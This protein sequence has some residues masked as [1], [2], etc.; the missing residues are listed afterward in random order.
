MKSHQCRR[1]FGSALL[2]RLAAVVI[3]VITAVVAIT[4]LEITPALAHGEKAQMPFLRMRSIQ[5]FDIAWSK[6]DVKVGETVEMT[7]KFHVSQYW[8][9]SIGEPKE[10]YLNVGQP[11]AVFVRKDVFVNG[12]FVPR[13]FPLEI[14]KTYEFK[15]VLL[16]RRP[17]NWHV[18]PV[19]NVRGGGPLSGPGEDINITGDWT[20][21]VNPVKSLDGNTVDLETMGLNGIYAWHFMWMGFAAL[22]IL[23]WYRRGGF[24]SRFLRVAGSNDSQPAD[25][26]IS[27][28]D[29]KVTYGALALTLL[30][31][32]VAFAKTEAAYPRTLPLQ[33]GILTLA[34]ADPALNPPENVQVKY[35]R[36]IYDVP[37]RRLEV[38]LEVTNNSNEPVQIGE[39]NT[40]SVRFLNPKVMKDPVKWPEYLLAPQGLSVSD[41]KPIAPGETRELTLL[42]QDA[43]WD[44]QRLSDIYYGTDSSI[45]GL[46]MLL[47]QSGTRHVIEIGGPAVPNYTNIG[48][49]KR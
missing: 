20:T 48:A 26:M 38:K 25:K 39:F 47:G 11:G 6:S 42:A 17:G 14:G 37:G 23:Y 21:F 5:W 19:M 31:V 41:D 32:I 49:L 35:L 10:T 2:G 1:A 29:E 9:D 8:P 16:A 15:I 45:A 30:I 44:T 34:P 12:T 27:P 18:H 40:A 22:W 28:M 46:L 43:L 4:S 3:G 7:G 13:A 33:S 36:A 24:I